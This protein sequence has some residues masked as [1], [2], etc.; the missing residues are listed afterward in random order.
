MK[1]KEEIMGEFVNEVNKI[2]AAIEMALRRLDSSEKK[3]KQSV[4]LRVAYE[5]EREDTITISRDALCVPQGGTLYMDLDRE[6]A[7]STRRGGPLAGNAFALNRR[8]T[9]ILG[10]DEQDVLCLV[11]HKK[12]QSN[13]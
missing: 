10:K 12:G 8:Y 3:E 13:G 11:P 2:S 7:I 4:T 5:A 6:W 9:W 1:T